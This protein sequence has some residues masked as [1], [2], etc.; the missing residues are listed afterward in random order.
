MFI[1][2]NKAEMQ[3]LAQEVLKLLIGKSRGE[4]NK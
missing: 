4:Y 3:P 2:H 1:K